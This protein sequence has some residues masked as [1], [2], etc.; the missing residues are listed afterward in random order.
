MRGIGGASDGDEV[1]NL[2]QAGVHRPLVEDATMP[3]RNADQGESLDS[4]RGAN[5]PDRQGTD[6]GSR[7]GKTHQPKKDGLVDDES[8][9]F[10]GYDQRWR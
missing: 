3:D 1:V 6:S 7:V 8:E 5:R 10:E 2:T 4:N 9:E